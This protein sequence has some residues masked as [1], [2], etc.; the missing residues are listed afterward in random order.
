MGFPDKKHLNKVRTKLEKTEGTLMLDPNA[1][2][3]DKLRWD[4]CQK[5]VQYKAEHEISQDELADMVG[6]DKAKISKIL[7]H[8]IDEFST[9]RLIAL[10]QQ[11]NPR[12]K[13]KVS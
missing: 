12:I 9:D 11:L 4:I 8:R 5:F 1:T 2:P 13:F 7:H 10:C 6:V 3:L